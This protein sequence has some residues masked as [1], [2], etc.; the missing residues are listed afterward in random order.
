MQ[1]S[2]PGRTGA[3]GREP[4][5]LPYPPWD[6]KSQAQ[7]VRRLP[8]KQ[9]VKGFFNGEKI[10][11]FPLLSDVPEGI[12]SPQRCLS[13][14]FC[15]SFSINAAAAFDGLAVGFEPSVNQSPTAD[16]KATGKM[17]VTPC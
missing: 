3:S 10:T 9:G 1:E 15:S 13:E 11:P 5:L 8:G 2:P 7:A 16:D 17:P 12:E 6:G 14:A 4:L